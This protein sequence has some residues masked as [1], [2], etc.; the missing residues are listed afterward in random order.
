[1]GAAHRKPCGVPDVRTQ[2]VVR[3]RPTMFWPY[4]PQ[5]TFV[6]YLQFTRSEQLIL[7]FNC[8]VDVIENMVARDGV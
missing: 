1:L 8:L 4:H 6:N 5:E 3:L 7:H 2:H